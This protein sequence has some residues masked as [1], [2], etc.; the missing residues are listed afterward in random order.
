[1][2]APHDELPAMGP[3]FGV[4]CA[5]RPVEKRHARCTGRT[6]QGIIK[7]EEDGDGSA[8]RGLMQCGVIA[9]PK[10]ST[11]PQYGGHGGSLPVTS[12]AYPGR[13]VR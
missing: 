7:D 4:E 13:T 2:A 8:S 9:E 5:Q 12:R 6:E 1:M 3:Q 10:V 11:Q